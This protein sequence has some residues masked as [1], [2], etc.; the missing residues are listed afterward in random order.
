MHEVAFAED[1][2]SAVRRRAGG[3]PVVAIRVRAGVLHRLDEASLQQAIELVGGGTEAADAVLELV[4]VP[5]GVS[6]H[7]CGSTS[8]LVDPLAVCPACGSSDVEQKGGDELTLE[9]ITYA[10]ASER[11][12]GDAVGGGIAG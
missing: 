9:S 8:E 7:A 1:I 6:C 4:Q 2:V 3:R 12:A 11:L 10:A 5:I